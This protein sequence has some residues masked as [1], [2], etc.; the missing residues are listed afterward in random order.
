MKQRQATSARTFRDFRESQSRA[1]EF[2]K[3]HY[4]KLLF[5]ATPDHRALVRMLIS[6]VSVRCTGH[7]LAI[8]SSRERCSMVKG[9]SNRTSRSVLLTLPSRVS[10]SNQDIDSI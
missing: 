7:L 5:E 1:G 9:P 10:P 3:F 6:E 2:L 4:A 8:S